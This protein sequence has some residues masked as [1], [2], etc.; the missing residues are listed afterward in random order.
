MPVRDSEQ[1]FQLIN[2]TLGYWRSQVLFT[3]HEL[4]IFRALS[5][6]PKASEEIDQICDSSH[7]HTDRLLNACVAIGLLKKENGRF[8]N[9]RLA[10]TLLVEGGLQYMGHWIDLM[11]AWYTPWGSLAEAI[12]TGK[13]VENPL[14]HLG[15]KSDYTRHFIMAMHDYAMGPGKEMVNHLDLSGRKTLLDVGGG[16][17]SYSILLAQK[18]PEL[19]AVVYDLP[20]VVEI[21]EEVIASYG[22]SG[23]VKVRG[24]N[25]L[26]DDLR[27]GAEG[28]DV[29]LLS[30]MLH[31]EDPE[32]C[33]MLLRK[34]KDA[35][36][37]DGLLVIQ[38]MFLN[39]EKDGPVWPTLQSLQLML[40]YQGGR[41]YSVDETLAM[42]AETGFSRPQAKRMSLLN[43]ESLIL[44]SKSHVSQV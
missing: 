23:R 28:Y 13:P 36:A 20:P 2:L 35:L 11:S 9:L 22:L 44:A 42:L 38:A 15:G 6:G 25:Y 24:G 3:A 31:Q 12:R 4:G 19:N 33:K 14:E 21:A 32:T 41:T 30:N 16:P 40:V 43:A 37:D 34:A 18:N 1:L 8:Q 5:G 39:S 10:E 27:D 17:G 26:E 7:G 29:L